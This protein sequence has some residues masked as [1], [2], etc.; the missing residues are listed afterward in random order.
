MERLVAFKFERETKR[1]YRFQEDSDAPVIGT[2]YVKQ[3]V[4]SKRP[5]RLEVVIRAA[6]E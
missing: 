4:F 1:T 3:S 5:G 6:D 2:L